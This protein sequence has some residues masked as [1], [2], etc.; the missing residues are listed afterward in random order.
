MSGRGDFDVD[1]VAALIAE[2]A[3]LA[4][5]ADAQP[6][7]VRDR[8]PL[9]AEVAGFLLAHPD[10][11]A[12]TVSA[13]VAGRRADVLWAVR[14]IRGSSSRFLSCGYHVP[15]AEPERGS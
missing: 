3:E 12:N 8:G 2:L 4:Q 1:R 7:R 9:V 15:E 11:T 14:E 10:A 13:S 5:C 6:D